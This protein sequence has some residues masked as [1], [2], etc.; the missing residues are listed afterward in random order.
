MENVKIFL[1]NPGRRDL[2]Y[3]QFL[4]P[5]SSSGRNCL[6]KYLSRIFVK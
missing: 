4:V 1:S 5:V 3:I 6:V 2:C